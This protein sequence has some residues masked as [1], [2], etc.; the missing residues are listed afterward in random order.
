MMAT[1]RTTYELLSNK[2]T[3]AIEQYYSPVDIEVSS[4]HSDTHFI[5]IKYNRIECTFSSSLDRLTNHTILLCNYFID[6]GS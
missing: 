6:H 3:N 1:K 4:L 5:S 2:N